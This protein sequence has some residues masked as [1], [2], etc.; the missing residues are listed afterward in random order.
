MNEISVKPFERGDEEACFRIRSEAFIKL[1][2]DSIGAD[3]VVAG[4]NGYLPRQLEAL[5]DAF[6][7]SVAKDG[8]DVMG[9]LAARFVREEAIEILFLYVR[10]DAFRKGVGRLLVHHLEAQVAE[11]HPEVQQILV[12]TVV[13]QLNQR[14]YEKLGYVEVGQSLCRY[15][16]RDIVA[17]RLS[18]QLGRQ[19]PEG[20]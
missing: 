5:S 4:V 17:V 18:K 15:P 13:P 8:E 3:G 11:Q 2:Y 9:F 12:D 6:P 14:F 10:S 20:S 16:D 7:L 1:F 19:P